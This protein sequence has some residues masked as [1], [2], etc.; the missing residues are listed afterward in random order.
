MNSAYDREQVFAHVDQIIEEFHLEKCKN[1]KI[2]YYNDKKGISGG[3]KRR[4][5]F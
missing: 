5:L 2:G 4:M 1:N 3:E